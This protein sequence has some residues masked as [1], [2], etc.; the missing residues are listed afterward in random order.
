MLGFTRH[1]LL[2]SAFDFLLRLNLLTEGR[3]A[4]VLSDNGGEFAKYFEQACQKL[5]ILHIFTR[6]RTPKDNSI[7]ERF[8]RTLQ[9]EFLEVDESFEPSLAENDLTKA[10]KLLTKWLIFYNFKRPHQALNYQTPIEY[11]YYTKGVSAMYPP[12][13]TS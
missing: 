7:N 11:T 10:N 8:N 6:V 12:S 5:G 13:T 3:I 2:L 1:P 4:A 9:E